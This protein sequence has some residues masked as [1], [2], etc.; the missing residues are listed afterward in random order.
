M[1]LAT[2]CTHDSIYVSK[3]QVFCL[4]AAAQI[5]SE[6]ASAVRIDAEVVG[7]FKSVMETER[8]E[9]SFMF[10]KATSDQSKNSH[11]AA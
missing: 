10:A 8:I 7:T 11:L 5:R 3:Q 6:K 9:F 2:Y 1:E 4:S